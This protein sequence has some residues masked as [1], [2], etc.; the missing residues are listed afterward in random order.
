MNT[1]HCDHEK[2][3]EDSAPV[4]PPL[5]RLVPCA[6]SIGTVPNDIICHRYYVDADEN[7]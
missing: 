1:C 6:P 5:R 2:V 7:E 3:R 4:A